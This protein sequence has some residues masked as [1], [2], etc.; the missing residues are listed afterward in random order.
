MVDD[1]PIAFFDASWL[2]VK[3]A[4]PDAIVEALELSDPRPVTWRQGL[5]PTRGDLLP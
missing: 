3:A 1:T 2:A 4:P 5:I